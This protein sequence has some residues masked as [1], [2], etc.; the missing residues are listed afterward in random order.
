MLSR[1]AQKQRDTVYRTYVTDALKLIAENTARLSNGGCIK[2]R[3]YDLLTPACED[4]RTGEQIVAD[5]I[6][7]AGLKVVK[8][9]E[10]I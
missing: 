2:A 8:K 9:T 6:K 10:R 4:A 5:V 7:N 3:F 1:Y